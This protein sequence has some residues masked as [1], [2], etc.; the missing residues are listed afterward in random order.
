MSWTENQV[1]YFPKPKVNL[2]K[3]ID[4]VIEHSRD[5]RWDIVGEAMRT[6]EKGFMS[7]FDESPYWDKMIENSW[8]QYRQEMLMIAIGREMDWLHFRL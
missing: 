2:S 8:K 3:A 1:A 4:F 7:K 6:L 5:A